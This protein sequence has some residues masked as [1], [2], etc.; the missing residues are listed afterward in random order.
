MIA[1]PFAKW[2]G[3]DR[4]RVNEPEVLGDTFLNLYFFVNILFWIIK[5]VLLKQ[6]SYR[7]QYQGNF[8][9]F[10][11]DYVYY[12]KRPP[13]WEASAL[14]KSNSNSLVINIRDIYI[15]SRSQWRL[16]AP[17]L[18]PVHVLHEHTWT[19]MNC[20]IALAIGMSAAKTSGPC[21]KSAYSLQTGQITSGSPLWRD[22]TKVFLVLN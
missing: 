1:Y 15:W 18:P 2:S 21:C 12:T 19:H 9:S 20:R 7:N 10:A 3:I 6:E 4:K 14:E 22:L 17:C 16:L 11:H 5:H 13:R 8:V